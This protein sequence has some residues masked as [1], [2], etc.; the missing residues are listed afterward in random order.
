[1]LEE[2]DFI[3][4]D[5]YPIAQSYQG[6]RI[7][8]PVEEPNYIRPLPGCF[9][10]GP[11]KLGTR[12]GRLTLKTNSFETWART[13][14]I[15]V[16]VEKEHRRSKAKIE[17]EIGEIPG[18]IVSITCL[19]EALCFPGYDA[20]YVNPTSRLALIGKC[21]QWCDGGELTYEW[22]IMSTENNIYTVSL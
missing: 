9:G 18:P 14:E 22:D 13:Y 7:P 20:V 5:G 1:M 16:V 10:S 19:S 4:E 11:V 15:M 2:Y 12:T 3:D 6:V 21:T 8:K 17:V